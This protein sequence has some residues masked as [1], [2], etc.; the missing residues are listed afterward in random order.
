MPQAPSANWKSDPEEKTFIAYRDPSGGLNTKRD[1]HALDRNMAAVSI[2]MWPAYD[3]ALS[4]RPGSSAFSGGKTGMAGTGTT[5]VATRWNVAGVSSTVLLAQNGVHLAYAQ[6][7]ATAWTPISTAM[8]AGAQRIHVAQT[9][10]PTTGGNQAFICNGVD[11]PWMW[12]G[13]GSS[14]LTPV[15]TAPGQLPQKLTS[16]TPITPR[17]VETVGNNSLLVY[18]GEPSAPTA[19]YVSNA[20]YPQNFS[21]SA[22]TATPYPGG[23]QPYL[24]GFN[25]GVNGGNITG[26]GCLQGNIIAFKETAIYRGQFVTIYGS[27]VGFQWQTVSAARGC[28]APESICSFD[29]FIVFLSSDG[30]Y[31]TDSYQL[32]QVSANVPTFFDGSLTGNGPIALNY[33]TAVGARSGARYLIFY[34]RGNPFTNGTPAGYPTS[35]LW[36]DF[37]KPDASALPQVGEMQGTSA[38]GG[39]GFGGGGQVWAVGGMTTLAGQNDTGLV[40]WIDPTQ[41]RVGLFG[42]GFNDFGAPISTTF[43]GVADMMPEIA[44]PGSHASAISPKHIHRAWLSI[45]SSFAAINMPLRFTVSIIT[46]LLSSTTTVGSTQN[47]SISGLA[48]YWDQGEWD[49][50]YWAGSPS[51]TDYATI[52]FSPA[53]SADGRIIQVQI[54]ESSINEWILLG[55]VL[56]ASAREP[57]L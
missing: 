3:N 32:Q 56:E 25:D 27:V 34:D 8:G 38:A 46:D 26:L 57:V 18:S 15:G 19:V 40:A 21:Q 1:A 53:T 35:G 42:L 43:A 7:G 14:L 52:S 39:G 44:N 50:N 51:A 12:S 54:T 49:V 13:P 2:N 5:V 29:T 17:F 6:V 33:T 41:D 47:L 16:G 55:Y 23:Y 22:T 20:F 9:F 4:K 10:D 11:V 45:A 37:S 48:L 36:F 31:F 30:V 28:V 24:V